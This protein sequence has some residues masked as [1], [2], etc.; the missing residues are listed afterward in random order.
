MNRAVAVVAALVVSVTSPH[1]QWPARAPANAPLTAAGE[2]DLDGPTPRSSDGKP[3]L[4]GTWS[5]GGR[6]TG[7]SY[8]GRDVAYAAGI[9]IAP[10]FV[11]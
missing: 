5:G 7:F 8:P 2:I 11:F 9:Y 6:P 1:A 3:D 4:S 10:L